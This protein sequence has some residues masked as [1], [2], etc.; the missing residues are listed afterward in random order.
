MLEKKRLWKSC[1][2]SF[3]LAALCSVCSVVGCTYEANTK[4]SIGGGIPP[5]FR[6]DGSGHQMYFVVSE[7]PPENQVRAADRNSERNIR[8][9]KILPNEGTADIA[10]DWPPITYGKVP[11]GFRQEIPAQVEPPQLT[12]GKVYSAGGPAYGAN[13]GEVWFTIRDGKS[14]EVPK[15][16]GY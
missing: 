5:T 14:V 4:V 15:P 12:E 2:L 13:G 16:G 3:F 8:L 6:I 1:R 7:I 10:W 9:W 11:T